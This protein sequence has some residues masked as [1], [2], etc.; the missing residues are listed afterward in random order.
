MELTREDIQRIDTAGHYGYYLEED[1]SFI[2]GNRNGKC[3]FLDGSGLCSI[4]PIRPEGCRLYPLV[5]RLPSGIAEIDS[6]CPHGDEFPADPDDV[7]RLTKLVA[8]LRG[9]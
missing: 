8:K 7:V 5:M 3:V 1:G 9:T 6:V 4:Y 2:L